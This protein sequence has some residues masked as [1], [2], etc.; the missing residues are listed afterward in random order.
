VA[1]IKGK[2]ETT[3]SDGSVRRF[4]PGDVVLLDDLDSKD[5]VSVGNGRTDVFMVFAGLAE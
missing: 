1:L 3:V 4:S 2:F 5:H